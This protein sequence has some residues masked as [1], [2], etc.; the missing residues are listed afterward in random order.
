MSDE[1]TTKR[2]RGTGRRTRVKGG[3]PGRHNVRTS[4]EEEGALQRLSLAAGMSVPRYLV[5]SGLA[6]ESG[7]TI[8]DRRSTITKLYE[9]HRLLAAISNNVNQIAKATNATRELHPETSATLAAVRKTAM[10][11]DE[12]T[13]ELSLT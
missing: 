5:E 7:E 13:D 2:E 11:I 1:S 4:A 6:M 8:T 3:R 12:L 10:R 9:L